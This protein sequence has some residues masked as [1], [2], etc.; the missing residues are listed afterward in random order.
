MQV[1]MSYSKQVNMHSE[2][3]FMSH[4]ADFAHPCDWLDYL[5][6]MQHNL[7]PA[8]RLKCLQDLKCLVSQSALMT[9][10][11]LEKVI[12]L[13]GLLCDW[14]LQLQALDQLEG[15]HLASTKAY[16]LWKL[17]QWQNAYECLHHSMFVTPTNKDN[18]A[19]YHHLADMSQGQ[20]FARYTQG[21]ITNDLSLEPL[22]IHHC[23]EY[24]WQSWNPETAQLCCLPHLTN[25]HQWYLWLGE[26]QSLNDQST[27]AVIHSV[28]GFIGVV[29]LIV[30]R[31]VG[32][33]YYWVGPDFQGKGFGPLAAQL[34]LNL[35]E[36]GLGINCCYAKV[37]F[38]NLASQ[39]ALKKIE[40]KDITH[41]TGVSDEG[42]QFFYYG[43][44]KAA[45]DQCLELHQ[46]LRDMGST[47]QMAM[48]LKWLI[49]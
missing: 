2:S 15:E 6:V 13:A 19:L 25:A 14:N 5:N 34:L 20:Y 47:T 23:D 21:D 26:Q 48:P 38:S 7:T 3:T 16:A 44:A 17:G 43:K 10:T 40:F 42:E 32:F 9:R 36:Q 27:F 28:H 18:Y 46:L 4:S 11:L 30:H 49:Q 24:L 22:N 45:K 35:G 29:S 33:F 39:K 8:Y 37:L 31:H 12:H 41:V 1:N